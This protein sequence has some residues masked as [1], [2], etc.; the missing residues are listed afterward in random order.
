[1]EVLMNPILE[2]MAVVAPI[3]IISVLAIA[4][5]LMAWDS[6][7]ERP[8]LIGEMLDRQGSD[9]MHMAL[10]SGGA[11]FARAVRRCVG[12]AE[13]A[14]CRSWLDAGRREG[15]DAFCPNA[16]YVE[17]IAALAGTR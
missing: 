4:A 8:V 9:A 11:D 3:V 10:A 17:R 13:A 16:G 6:L 5:S 14:R 15:Y 1:M 2:T 12:C 7:D